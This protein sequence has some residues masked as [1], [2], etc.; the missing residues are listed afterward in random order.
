MREQCAYGV[1]GGLEVDIDDEHE[2]SSF[3]SHCLF[4]FFPFMMCHICSSYAALNSINDNSHYDF[5]L[6]DDDGGDLLSTIGRVR[7]KGR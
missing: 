3:M 7:E 6:H 5:F 1:G 2:A 4:V